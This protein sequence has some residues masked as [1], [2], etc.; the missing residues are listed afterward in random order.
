MI[1][2][3]L[4]VALSCAGYAMQSRC[5]P[6]VAAIS[7]EA[8]LCSDLEEPGAPPHWLKGPALVALVGGTEGAVEGPQ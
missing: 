1:F 5:C 6:M 7:L 4:S 3:V 8:R 2:M